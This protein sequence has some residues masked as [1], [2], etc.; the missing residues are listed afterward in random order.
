MRTKTRTTL[1]AATLGLIAATTPAATA[2]P[3]WTTQPT[4]IAGS[5]RAFQ[6]AVVDLRVGEHKRFD[7]VVIDIRGRRPGVRA[8][9]TDR[10]IYPG[11]GRTVPL[12]GHRKFQLVLDPARAHSLT[13]GTTT[14]HGPRLKQYQLPTL[15]GVAFMGDFEGQVAF[16]FTTDRVARYRIFELRDPTRVVLDFHH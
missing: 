2:L 9:Y 6:P 7:R 4:T 3:A 14:Y 13:T 16:G 5:P 11:S 1:A 8:N 12:R 15:R 10:L